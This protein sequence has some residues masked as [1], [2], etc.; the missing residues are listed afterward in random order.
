MCGSFPEPTNPDLGQCFPK[1]L[2]L[3]CVPPTIPVNPCGDEAVTIIYNPNQSPPFTIV[4]HTYDTACLEIL[5]T[6][7]APVTGPLT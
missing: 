6:T 7:G 2:K 1:S 4:A 5:D 3:D